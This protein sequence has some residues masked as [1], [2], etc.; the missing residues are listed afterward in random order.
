[1]FAI[2][3]LITLAAL[4]LSV[5]VSDGE[6]NSPEDDAGDLDVDSDE[7][8]DEISVIPDGLDVP[9]VVFPSHGQA[10][11]TN[12]NFQAIDADALQTDVDYT[13]AITVDDVSG[14]QEIDASKFEN[15]IVNSGAGDTVVGSDSTGE[16]GVFVSVSTGGAYVEGGSSNG[17]FMTTGD[18][19]SIFAGKGDDLVIGGNGASYLNGDDGDDTIFSSNERYFVTT[20]TTDIATFSDA[21][22]DTL[23]GGAGDDLIYLGTGDEGTGGAGADTIFAIGYDIFVTDFEWGVDSLQI[24]LSKSE[25]VDHVCEVDP[26]KV[27]E[28]LTVEELDGILH[29]TV[30]ADTLVRLPDGDDV[31]ICFHF[32]SEFGDTIYNISD[33]QPVSKASVLI[34]IY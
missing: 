4:G 32:P 20:R 17:V 1:V 16:G 28:L 11:W 22:K 12:A 6:S 5:L 15:S 23:N 25:V 2:F 34:S 33:G 8:G 19:D 29:I 7:S 18:E 10:I 31:S 21:S 3:G 26:L 24:P 30:G 9:Q 27:A 13:N 14:A